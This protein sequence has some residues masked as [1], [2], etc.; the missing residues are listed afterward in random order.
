VGGR[1]SIALSVTHMPFASP[2]SGSDGR[3][4]AI[5]NTTLN[6]AVTTM[7]TSA[8][9]ISHFHANVWS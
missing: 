6:T 3:L 1:V 5:Y 7:L 8:A 9:G 4:V 2:V